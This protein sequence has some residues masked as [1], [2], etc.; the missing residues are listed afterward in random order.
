M[1]SHLVFHPALVLIAAAFLLPFLRGQGR[2]AVILLAPIVSL[3]A[4]WLLPEGR[5][6]EVTWLDYRLAPLA[7]DKLSRLFATIF[8]LMAFAGGLFALRV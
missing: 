6:W 1:S 4:L 8:G 2:N 5:L 7:V 3:I